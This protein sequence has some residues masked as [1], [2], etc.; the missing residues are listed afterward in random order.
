[1]GKIKSFLKQDSNVL[2]DVI[3]G[4]FC[5]SLG[6]FNVFFQTD[7]R[8]YSLIFGSTLIVGSIFVIVW[9]ILEYKRK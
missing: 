3:A 2:R 8:T 1:M 7:H 6:I 9:S 5:L 4:L